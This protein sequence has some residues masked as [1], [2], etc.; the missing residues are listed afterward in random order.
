MAKHYSRYINILGQFNF[1]LW[2][3]EDV[4]NFF[5]NMRPL[6][7]K[8]ILA[9]K[10]NLINQLKLKKDHTF[11]DSLNEIIIIKNKLVNLNKKKLIVMGTT[12]NAAFVEEILKKN[13]YL[14][15][16]EQVNNKNIFRNKKVIHPNK[17]KNNDE[18]ILPYDKKNKKILGKFRKKYN[19]NFYLI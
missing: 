18:I 7:R 16:D 8:L 12:I 19:G 2:N 10:N 13:I 17:L 9:R 6:N 5:K 1:N 3:L 4:D 15:T 14:F 11:E